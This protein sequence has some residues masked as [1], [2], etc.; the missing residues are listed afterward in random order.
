ME[1]EEL[2]A[3][4]VF[5]A[6]TATA[7]VQTF[8][9]LRKEIQADK[10]FPAFTRAPFLSQRDAA[11]KAVEA[12]QVFPAFTA[13][14][15]VGQ[16]AA[17]RDI[18]TADKTFPAFVSTAVVGKRIAGP[19]IELTAAKTY[20]AATFGPVFLHQ[21]DASQKVVSASIHYPQFTATL[22]L[23]KGAAMPPA[24]VTGL[25]WVESGYQTI[26]V[27]FEQPNP[28]TG[29]LL[30]YEY[31]VD[32]QPWGSTMSLDT[33]YVITGLMSGTEYDIRI[34][35]VSNVG[36]GP[37]SMPLMART[38]P[39]TAPQVPLRFRVETPGGGLV[40][41]SWQ[42]PVDDGGDPITHYEF[43]VTD[44]DGDRLPVDSTGTP[45]LRARTRGLQP[46]Q[47]YGFH[48][49]AVNSIGAS[50]WTN[51]LYAVPIIGPIADDVSGLRIPLLDLD[52]QSLIV[53]LGGQDC[54]IAVWWQP[55]D[56]SWFAGLEVPV[57]TAIVDG[58]RLVV[59]AGLLDRIPGV[60]P[61]NIILRAIDEDSAARDPARD[62][63]RRQTHGL[64]YEG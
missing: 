20:A 62:A 39:I 41:Q 31:R 26:T 16:R 11:Q 57:N 51:I 52:R 60:L 48:V 32:S 24:Q 21:R 56:A 27:D 8:A 64:I 33:R 30:H 35:A 9:G 37:A 50:A 23:S 61:G 29:I 6:F 43:Q 59:N 53:R 40:D 5:P 15:T 18:V 17:Q 14:V 34:R 45:S 63:W 46:Y 25:T 12:A 58:I 36:R 7:T 55:S 19:P 10:T 2:T 4:K 42:V 3:V 1:T 44:P 22:H 13:A 47:R 38:Q 28:G 54:R 49:R